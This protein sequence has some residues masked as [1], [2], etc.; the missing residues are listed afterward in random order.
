MQERNF[1]LPRV[2]ALRHQRGPTIGVRGLLLYMPI[3]AELQQA[4]SLLTMRPE[5]KSQPEARVVP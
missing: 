3:A 5:K 2:F 4:R 1:N